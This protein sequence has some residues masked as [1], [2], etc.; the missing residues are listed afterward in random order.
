MS[1]FVRVRYLKS[2]GHM[3]E[4]VVVYHTNSRAEELLKSG[5]IE[6]VEDE[7]HASNKS[8]VGKEKLIKRV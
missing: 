5:V 1:E 8:F 3:V 4:G 7:E 6:I 2:H